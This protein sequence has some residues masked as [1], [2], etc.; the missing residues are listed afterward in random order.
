MDGFMLVVDVML[1]EPPRS[2]MAAD[3]DVLTEVCVFGQVL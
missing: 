2:R 1:K 3:E